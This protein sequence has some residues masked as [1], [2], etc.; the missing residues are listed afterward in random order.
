[1]Q[2]LL[3]NRPMQ[4]LCITELCNAPAQAKPRRINR[5]ALIFTEPYTFLPSFRTQQGYW[6]PVFS[7]QASRVFPVFRHYWR[8]WVSVGR[9]L[10]Q[11]GAHAGDP[12]GL[13][14]TSI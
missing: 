3:H 8:V 7:L 1:M 4:A 11:S 5:I 14:D 9:E 6:L 2:R 12:A 13:G 10:A